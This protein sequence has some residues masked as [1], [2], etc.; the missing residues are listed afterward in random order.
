M[1]KPSVEIE[2]RKLIISAT[3]QV[4]VTRGLNQ[5]RIADVAKAAKLSSGIIHYYFDSKEELIRDTF[6]QSFEE[7]LRSREKIVTSGLP[8]GQRLIALIDSYIPRDEVTIEAWHVWLQLWAGA[9]REEELRRINETA[10]ENWRNLISSVILECHAVGALTSSDPESAA[11]ALVA[12]IDGLAVQV[13]LKSPT[14]DAKTMS[15]VCTEFLRASLSFN[16]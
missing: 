14:I 12:L 1:S 10:Y 5:L 9:L 13:L 4:M 16:E 7:S 8:P 15:E 3:R 11:N 2:R 6:E